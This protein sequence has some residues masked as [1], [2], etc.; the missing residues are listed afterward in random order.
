MGCAL[1]PQGPSL[2]SPPQAYERQVPP[3]AVINSAGYKILTSVDRYLELVGNSLPG[4]E[5]PIPGPNALCRPGI[6]PRE[7]VALIPELQAPYLPKEQLGQEP[8]AG[9]CAFK[10]EPGGGFA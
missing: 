3:R 5:P 6:W 1:N 10:G 2:F 8:V 7:R 4:K 9:A